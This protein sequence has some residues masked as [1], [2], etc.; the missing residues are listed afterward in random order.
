[1]KKTRDMTQ[2]IQRK[3]FILAQHWIFIIIFWVVL[4]L[5]GSRVILAS[6]SYTSV[7]EKT[8]VE[9]GLSSTAT[10]K[11]T[12]TIVPTATKTPT[13]TSIQPTKIGRAHV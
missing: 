10:A 6:S 11:A 8:L 7:H 9:P 5:S 4:L 2:P 3:K 13:P 12:S 1:M